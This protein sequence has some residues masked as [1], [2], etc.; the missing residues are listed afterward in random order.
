MLSASHLL[1]L[2]IHIQNN[3]S[4]TI[5]D[6]KLTN[7]F[8]LQFIVVIIFFVFLVCITTIHEFLS[9]TTKTDIKTIEIL[10]NSRTN[11]EDNL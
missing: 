11:K 8:H 9:K 5:Q 6:A 4:F 3:A 10:K 7:Y 2:E 1:C